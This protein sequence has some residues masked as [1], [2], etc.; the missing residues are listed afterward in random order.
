MHQV[1]ATDTRHARR[2]PRSTKVRGRETWRDT[3]Q[4]RERRGWGGGGWGAAGETGHNDN[5]S[6][7][8][9]RRQSVCLLFSASYWSVWRLF[10]CLSWQS[11]SLSLCSV[12]PHACLLPADM[13][14]C[15]HLSAPTLDTQAVGEVGGT[16]GSG[17]GTELTQT[18]S[19]FICLP[20][21]VPSFCAELK[22]PEWLMC[23]GT[24]TDI[25]LEVV[26]TRLFMRSQIMRM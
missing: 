16:L 5:S 18:S 9:M 6:E 25:W 13:W 22:R 7:E 10:A 8:K 24:K 19:T 3:R 2:S 14:C 1:L 11:L 12:W 26:P 20:A 4:E 21:I 17:L 23:L 15:S